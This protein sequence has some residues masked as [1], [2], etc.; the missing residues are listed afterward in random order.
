[1]NERKKI[2]LADDDITSLKLGR[3]ALSDIYE[4]T[5]VPSGEKL[6][7]LL[8]NMTPD[9]I[10]LDVEM[11]EMNGYE[12]IKRIKDNPEFQNIPV[13]FV[14][15]LSSDNEEETGLLLG[16]V[17]YV[18]K[19]FKKAILRARINTH[20]QIV[21]LMRELE[22][23]TAI[24]PLTKISNRRG[25]D[26]QFKKEW[27][28]AVE[29]KFY[30]GFMI[31]DADDF[32]SYNDTY[33]HSQGDVLLKKISDVFNSYCKS[34]QGIAAR[35]GGEEFVL[36]LPGADMDGIFEAA[37]E[38]RKNIESLVIHTGSGEETSTTI[39][40]GVNSIIPDN[41]SKPADFIDKADQALYNAKKTGKNKVLKV[42]I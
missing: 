32:K 9:L 22:Q 26:A 4:I 35:W 33:G 8:G 37:E 1:M 39:S 14:T 10:L 28:R 7:K 6:L 31:I 13:I 23:L 29:S 36:L 17:D 34:E 24:D 21:E 16:A 11:P 3:D 5:T 41:A 19:P 12:T 20:L 40:I 2:I 38:I 30:I 18:K 15:G 42:N 25:F 27:K